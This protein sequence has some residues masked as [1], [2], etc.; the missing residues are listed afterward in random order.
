M[1][2]TYVIYSISV[3]KYYVGHT[4]NL[5][6]RIFRHNSGTTRFTSQANDWEIVYFEEFSSK[7]DAMKRENEIKRKKS[8]SYIESLKK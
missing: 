8:R 2:Y 5:E 4:E 1:F 3:D 6:M 7:S